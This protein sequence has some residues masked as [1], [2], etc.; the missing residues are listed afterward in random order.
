MDRKSSWRPP[1]HIPYH[2]AQER[3]Q[4]VHR[5]I[6]SWDRR[7]LSTPKPQSIVQKNDRGLVKDGRLIGCHLCGHAMRS[8]LLPGQYGSCCLN[9]F[10]QFRPV[11]CGEGRFNVGRMNGKRD[12]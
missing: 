2:E 7:S 10:Q 1:R 12:K 6:R 5:P 4:R 8:P 11:S 9:H 3:N